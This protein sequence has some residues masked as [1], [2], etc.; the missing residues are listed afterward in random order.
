IGGG[1]EQKTL[2][3]TAKYAD[4]W[5]GFGTPEQMTHKIEVLHGHCADVGR[6]P[7]AIEPWSGQWICVR[8]DPEDARQ[9]LEDIRTHHHGMNPP[10]AI[11]GGSDAVAKRLKEFWDAGVR[12]FVV[13]FAYP[14]DLETIERLATEVRPQLG[15]L[16]GV[17]AA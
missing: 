14:Y 10:N 9:V 7:A 1:G 12:G 5:H 6:D 11:T 16:I 4:M 15:D 17:S 13:G 2:R 3:T 8:D